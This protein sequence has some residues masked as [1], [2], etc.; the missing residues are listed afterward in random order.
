MDDLR[1]IPVDRLETDQ[2]AQEL[3]ALAREIAAHREAYYVEDNPSISDAEFDALERRNALIEQKFPKLNRADSPSHSVGARASVK[4]KKITHLAPMLSLD[5]AFDDNDVKD[6][7]ARFK[8]FLSLDENEIIPVTAE[9]KID[10]LSLSIT[11]ENGQFIKAST[12]GDGK[13]GE[14]VSANVLTI[15]QI[16]KVL[17]TSNPPALLEICLLYT[18]RCV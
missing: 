5:N 1:N 9:P 17:N 3:E 6:F 11:Y 2:A 15:S 7:F 4:F 13:I 12:R 16:P 18:S 10:G 8:R 14:D